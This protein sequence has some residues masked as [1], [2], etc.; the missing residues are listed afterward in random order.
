MRGRVTRGT[1]QR[2]VKGGS[3]HSPQPVR[4]VTASLVVPANMA[5]ERAFAKAIDYTRRNMEYYATRFPHW[6]RGALVGRV[7]QA[8]FVL[9]DAWSRQ[10]LSGDRDYLTADLY[11]LYEEKVSGMWVH[12]ER[13]IIRDISLR[14]QDVS[15]IFSRMGEERQSFIVMVFASMYDYVTNPAGQ[16]VSGNRDKKV[17]FREFW[18][19]VWQD[20]LWKLSGIHEED[21]VIIARIKNMEL[22]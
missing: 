13:D 22:S 10:D 3:G 19:F 17:Y 7:R 12:G 4:R 6:D 5:F 16:V 14:D 20:G 1:R 21:S 11:R 8:F 2:R 18:E 9:Q 15:F